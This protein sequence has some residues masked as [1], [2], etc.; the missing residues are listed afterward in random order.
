[1]IE[2]K[3]IEIKEHDVEGFTML[4]KILHMRYKLPKDKVKPADLLA[5]AVLVDKYLCIEAVTLSA[6][7][8]FS[9]VENPSTPVEDLGQLIVAAFLLEQAELFK[10]LTAD[11]IQRDP[12]A[13]P[14][15]TS[16]TKLAFTDGLPSDAW[17][18]QRCP[19]SL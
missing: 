3:D 7:A 13:T 1:M 10:Q 17:C 8:F 9:H 16:V 5:F 18:K 11:L 14:P 4:C 19:Q 12:T 2:G 6:I 15:L